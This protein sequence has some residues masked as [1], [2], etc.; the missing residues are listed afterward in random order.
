M[1]KPFNWPYCLSFVENNN[2][3]RHSRVV[4]ALAPNVGRAK[5]LFLEYFKKSNLPVYSDLYSA[6]KIINTSTLT[7]LALTNVTFLSS[8][9]DVTEE[10]KKIRQIIDQT[11]LDKQ[12][13]KE[14]YYGTETVR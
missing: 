10:W 14:L 5:S 7:R 6:A 2:V 13:V 9:S 12:L 8:S 3:I 1:N 4:M 11:P